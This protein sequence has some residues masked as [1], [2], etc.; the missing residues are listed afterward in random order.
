MQVFLV[1]K[2]QRDPK[3][4]RARKVT[5]ESQGYKAPRG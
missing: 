1:K 4:I 2:V 5:R 3:E